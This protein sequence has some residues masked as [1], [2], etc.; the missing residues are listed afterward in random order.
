MVLPTLVFH[1]PKQRYTNYKASDSDVS[2]PSQIDVKNTDYRSQ[3][4]FIVR[5]NVKSFRRQIKLVQL[6]KLVLRKQ[7]L[8]KLKSFQTG[9]ITLKIS[10]NVS[11]SLWCRKSSWYEHGSIVL[12]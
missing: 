2:T 3:K 5:M 1:V 10:G 9:L 8:S 12:T 4:S 6:S 7:F 11:V